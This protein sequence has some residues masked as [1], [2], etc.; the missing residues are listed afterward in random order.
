MIFQR[1]FAPGGFVGFFFGF[2]SL[3]LYIYK[4]IYNIYYI[5]LYIDIGEGRA[6]FKL[7]GRQKRGS[8]NENDHYTQ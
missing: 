1:P 5:L 4:Y 6:Q 8:K 2:R 3:H 7:E